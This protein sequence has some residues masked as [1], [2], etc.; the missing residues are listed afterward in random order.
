MFTLGIS[1]Y[2]HDSAACLMHND[3]II[4]AVQE[5][6][7][8]RTKHDEGFPT[9]A[10]KYCLDE[11]GISLAEIDAVVYY[12]KPFL[13]F[14]RLLE[15]FHSVAPRGLS[16]FV[17]SMPV[18]IR[19]K[20]FIKREII[21]SLKQI[22][23]FNPKKTGIY[24]SEHHLSHAASTFYA[25]NFEE[26]AILTIDGMGEWA[27]ASIGIGKGNNIEILKELHYPNSV[28]LLYSAFTYFLGFVVNSGEY[29]LMGLAPYG[30]PDSEST[31]KY[32]EIIK[33]EFVEIKDDGSIRLN[34]KYFGFADSLK[35]IKTRK[36]EKLLGLKLRKPDDKIEQQH[37]DL[38]LAI[39]LVTE[40]IILKMAKFAAKLSGMQNLC[41]AGGVSLNCVANGR[42]QRENIFEEIYIQPA[43]GDAGGAVGA[44]LAY[45]FQGKSFERKIPEIDMMNG[46]YL[47]PEYSDK[48]IIK[49]C[50][51]YEAKYKY[52][53][54][55]AEL[56]K[57]AASQI[58]DSKVVGWFQGR[59]EFGPRALGNRSILADARNP[60]MQ[61]KLN[62]SIKYREGFRPFAPSVI[63]EDSAQIFEMTAMSPY[64]LLVTHV[65]NELRHQ[66]PDNYHNL[67][68]ME[69]L[70]VQRSPFPSITHC[71]YSARIQT[72][73][74]ET[75]P[76]YH[77]LISEVKRISGSGIIVNTSFNVRGEPI[78][79]TPEDAYRC[80]IRTEMDVLVMNNFV[81]LKEEQKTD[82]TEI[83]DKFK[84]D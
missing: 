16:P 12:E 2:Y 24:Y 62:L 36:W 43:A 74:K 66:A 29:K 69:K 26:A 45:V 63:A 65:K 77:S 61:K 58:A 3:K 60:E 25:S 48:E 13:K 17:K 73:H 39:Q 11:A 71:D 4:A 82:K 44:A 38:A 84:P 28:G 35:M 76:K 40:E 6:R 79:C 20:L 42:L 80:F 50:N 33:S 54:N 67:A 1:A 59:M 75:N 56:L 64:M 23:Q 78:V 32:M 34:M 10:V 81:F 41:L 8:T 72:V 47:G 52:Y 83:R 68:V 19:E 55:E 5:E 27:S 15:N 37:S 53:D 9:N 57:I 30:N 31:K 46:S 21:S 22:G 7:F 18:W 70:Y 51:K 14:E 49:V